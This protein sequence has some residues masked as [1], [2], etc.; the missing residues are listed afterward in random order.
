MTKSSLALSNL[1]AVVILIV[2]AFHSSLAYLASNPEMGRFDRPPF[3]WEAFPIIDAHRW[4]GFDIFCAWQDVSLMALMFFLSGLLTGPSLERK[5]A[6]VYM[7]D[8]LRRIG[9]PFVWAVLLLSPLAL[10]PAYAVRTAEPSAGDFW[11]QWFSLPFWPN[12]PQWFLW[13]LVALNA[14]AALLFVLAPGLLRDLRAFA[15]WAGRRPLRYFLIVAGLATVLYTPFA[16]VFSPWQWLQHGPLALQ[17]C[18]PGLYVVVFFAGLALGSYGLDRGLLACDGPLAR[19]WHWWLAAALLSF[20]LWAGCTSLTFPH[21]STASVAAKLGASLTYAPACI[22]GGTLMLALFLRF[23]RMRSRIL[24]SLSANAYSMYLVHYVFVVWLQYTLLPSDL[25]A[26]I[27]VAIVF[28]GAVALSWPAAILLNRLLAGNFS[29]AA[30][31]PA[32]TTSR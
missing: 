16:F 18:R 17:L 31:R 14:M 27:K 5:G 20:F 30:K 8:R 26:P 12:G 2:L 9:L 15:A 22:A 21:W 6:R 7:A 13:Q 25:V 19:R 24:D 32:W 4:I 23:S 1:R 10:Y 28:A 3:S 29:I 11:H